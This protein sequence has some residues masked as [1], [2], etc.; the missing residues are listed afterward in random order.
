MP[1]GSR[2]ELVSFLQTEPSYCSWHP[3]T[4][5]TSKTHECYRVNRVMACRYGMV[6]ANAPGVAATFGSNACGYFLLFVPRCPGAAAA[7]LKNMTKSG[8]RGV[9]LS[10]NPKA[11]ETR[12]RAK[13][14]DTTKKSTA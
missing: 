8:H 10:P 5:T 3:L 9:P 14:R 11:A 2:V 12:T 4:T 6:V 7:F 1:V 13:E